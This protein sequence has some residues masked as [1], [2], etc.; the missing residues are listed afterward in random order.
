MGDVRKLVPIA[1]DSDSG[2]RDIRSY[3]LPIGARGGAN[4][5][6]LKSVLLSNR[7]V[8]AHLR[9]L[10]HSPIPPRG[11]ERLDPVIKLHA[12]RR[13]YSLERLAPDRLLR[14]FFLRPTRVPGSPL[15][16]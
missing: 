7:Q 4:H 5:E 6:I 2:V 12:Q 3:D 9:V 11:K 15:R 8:A 14:P 13:I 10:V 16:R 1:P